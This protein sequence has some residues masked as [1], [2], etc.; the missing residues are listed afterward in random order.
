MMQAEQLVAFGSVGNVEE[1]VAT[2]S[3]YRFAPLTLVQLKVGFVDIPLA[4]PDGAD[5]V[6]ADRRAGNGRLGVFDKTT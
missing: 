6:G 4:P 5:K 3:Q 2:V 1:L